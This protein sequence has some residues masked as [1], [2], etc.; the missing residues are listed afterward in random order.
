MSDTDSVTHWIDALKAGDVR[1][2]QPLWEG[3]FHRLVGLA[4]VRLRGVPTPEADAEDVALS[5]FDSFCRA[6]EQGRFPRLDDRH[7]LWHLL[8]LLTAR[9]AANLRRRARA[10]KRGGGRV[11]QVEPAGGDEADVLAEVVGREPSP[12]FAAEVAEACRRLLDRLP[13]ATLRQVALWKMEG[14]RNAEIAAKI[15][16]AEETVERKLQLIRR[17]WEQEADA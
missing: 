12:E 15:G 11:R 7:D 2:V 4:G 9:K 5:A 6:A 13:D 17:A 10:R 8:V 16:R 1:A 14:Y 3:Y